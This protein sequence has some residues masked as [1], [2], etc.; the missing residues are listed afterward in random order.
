VV[1]K[2]LALAPASREALV[3]LA[4]LGS[5]SRHHLASHLEGDSPAI[6]NRRAASLLSVLQRLGLV[7]VQDGLFSL[8]KAGR[9]HAGMMG[10]DLKDS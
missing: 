9:V 3:A 2:M 8:T 10:L 4:R 6:R 7:Q 1:R 5:A